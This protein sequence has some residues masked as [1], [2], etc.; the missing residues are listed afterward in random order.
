MSRGDE[1]GIFTLLDSGRAKRNRKSLIPARL[2]VL[3][4]NNEGTPLILIQAGVAGLPVMKTNVK[5]APEVV[6][7]DATRILTELGLQ[8]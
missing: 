6:L 3:A 5:Y 2:V 1:A 7:A 4:G 8:E